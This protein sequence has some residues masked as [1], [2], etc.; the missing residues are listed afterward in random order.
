MNELENDKHIHERMV[1]RD[2]KVTKQFRKVPHQKTSWKNDIEG[3]RN[4]N[5]S[6]LHEWAAIQTNKILIGDDSLPAW[7]THGRT[8][9]CQKVS[10]KGDAVENCCPIERLQE[11]AHHMIY[12]LDR[13]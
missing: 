13:L 11:N 7:M 2:E 9:P 12:G 3:Y 5:V 1:V 6:S 10:R 8:L 4:K